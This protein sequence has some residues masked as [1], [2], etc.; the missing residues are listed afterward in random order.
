MAWYNSPVRPYD[1]VI[2][3]APA[4]PSHYLRDNF[5]ATGQESFPSPPAQDQSQWERLTNVMPIVDGTIHQRWGY[6]QFATAA[7][8]VE[9]LFSYERETDG[10][11][12]IVSTSPVDASAFLENGASYV[13]SFLP[14][15]G[16]PQRLVPSRSYAYAYNGSPQYLKKWDGNSSGN[17]TN[18]GIDINNDTG[19]TVEGPSNPVTV[20]DV[21]FSTSMP[22]S[23]PNNIK[24]KDG[25]YTTVGVL[26]TIGSDGLNCTNY[27]FSATGQVVGISV[28]ITGH[29]ASAGQSA[30]VSVQPLK[31]G[32]AY[33]VPKG[34]TLNTTTD[35]TLVFGSS[36][37]LWGGSWFA[38]DINS[39]NFGVQVVVPRLGGLHGAATV[40]L[41]DCQITVYLIGTGPSIGAPVAGS[42]TL[43][44]GRVYY[45]S[46]KNSLTGHYSDV[47]G[48]SPSTGPQTNKE[49]PLTLPVSADPQ[50]DTTV[51]LATADGGD[52][53]ILYLVTEVPAG[54]TSFTDNTP[55]TQL[56]LNQQL[57]FTDVFGNETGIPGNTPPPNGSLFIKHRGRLYAAVGETI[58]FSKNITDLTMPNGFIAGKYEE[59]WPGD[60]SLDISEGAETIQ[61]MLSDGVNLYIGTQRHVRILY[62]DGPDTFAGPEILH[63]EVGVANPDVWQIVFAEGQ[64]VG[65]M[66]IT[67]DLRVIGSDFNTYGD[68]GA[69][70]QDVLN[71]INVPAISAAH[72]QFVTS[73]SFDL[74]ILHI[75]T[76]VNT[77]CDTQ[78][79]FD[80]RTRRWVVWNL[81]DPSVAS[82]F[83]VNAN[84]VPQW[85]FGAGTFI[86][87]LIPTAFQDRNNTTPVTFTST[88]RTSWM[89]MGTPSHRKLLN[90]VEIIGNANV[91]FTVEGASSL[92]DF[93]APLSV[94]S[95]APLVLTPFGQYAVYLAGFTAKSRYY[96]YTFSLT[97]PT[98]NSFLEGYDIYNIPVHQL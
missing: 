34:L 94:L 76:G 23:N 97:D 77:T 58:F 25:V 74:Y 69:P 32:S 86:Y 89:H 1:P 33:G 19:A 4:G 64:P 98:T 8:P 44:I 79:V 24:L 91:L 84:G 75:P 35:S 43:T 2:E 26:N 38:S 95:A 21:P 65:S 80:L 81:T 59:S 12:A 39:S 40:A 6:N 28:S 47:S 92:Q 61:A 85:F 96:R 45:I 17:S 31:G 36:S 73:A 57:A 41:D 48:A 93:A 42:V 83:N 9:H 72:A 15:T 10:L 18:W 29:V 30:T 49:F 13:A 54:T 5:S 90:E 22:W 67:P 62:G 50:V 56:L 46:F 82:L 71:T 87:Q 27:G 53:S 70:I 11:R 51:L 14:T 20:V 55:E 63:N 68:V 16:I 60:N 88:A 37:D 66:W 52:P 78:C 7:N 3:D